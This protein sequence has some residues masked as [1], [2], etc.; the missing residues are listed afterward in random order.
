MRLVSVLQ[1][2]QDNFT[3]KVQHISILIHV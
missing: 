2:E 1:A 3:D